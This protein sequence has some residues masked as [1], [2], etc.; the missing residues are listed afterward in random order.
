[1]GYAYE[2]VLLAVQRH[3]HPFPAELEEYVMRYSQEYNIPPEIILS[4]IRAESSFR[5]SVVSHAGAVGL[6]QIMPTTFEDLTS[7]TG[8]HH[9]HGMLF[10]PA[11]NIRYGTF[12]LRYLF[13]MFGD[14]DL[15]FAA[16]N[17]GLGR[18]RG[19]MAD[20]EIVQDGELIIAAIPIE[21]TRN[22]VT[23]VNRNIEMYRKLYFP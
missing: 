5:S 23:R 15:T 14:W 18:V 7:R 8:G 21:E 17:A 11:T 4:V 1:M 22:Y 19:W 13:D 9:E 2:R 3:T 10:D 12:Y 6:M 20:S 16:Y